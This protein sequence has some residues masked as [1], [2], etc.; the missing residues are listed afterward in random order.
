VCG[1][2]GKT[3][4]TRLVHAILSVRLRGSCPAKS[5][6]NDIG[7]PLT[8][9]AARE[10]DQFLICEVGSNA[11]GEIALLASVV[12]PDI[13][14]ITSIGR[15]HLEKLG[16]L[17]GVAREE[18]AVLRDI[19]PGGAAIVTADSPLLADALRVLTASGRTAITFGKS[20]HADL[21]LSS[22]EHFASQASHG[23]N[24]GTP[25]H[26]GAHPPA[27]SIRFGVNARSTFTTP[28]VGEH[29]ALNAIAAIG[30]ARRMGLSD[31]DIS[32]GLAG[33][34]GPDMRLQRSCVGGVT[35]I[36]DAYNANPESTLAALRTFAQLYGSAA[37]RVVVLGDNRELGDAGPDAHRELG[38]AAVE[39][40][41][42]D[43][44]ICVG[45]LAALAAEVFQAARGPQAVARFAD[46]EAGCDRDAARL[47]QAGDAV[48][49]K[50]S[51]RMGLERIVT[52]L[53]G[54]A[55]SVAP[56]RGGSVSAPPSATTTR[57]SPLSAART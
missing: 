51:R 12:Q 43:R 8:I 33:A 17:E 56:G 45:E 14:V 47:L 22:L 25:S 40:A 16:S 49:L 44:L 19:R 41:S 18:A 52:A 15:E 23:T 21:R 38:R 53:A 26:E 37:R 36:N 20:D 7:V 31:G 42:I 35:I 2:N 50:G 3:T 57:S 39:L 9:L 30:V 4:T 1:S 10:G 6:N 34:V 48:L 46:L 29:N 28:M 11:P 54:A 32:V 27:D 24:L 5:F 13:A 55:T